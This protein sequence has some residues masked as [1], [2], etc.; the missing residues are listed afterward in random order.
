MSVQSIFLKKIAVA[1]ATAAAMTAMLSASPVAAAAP[2]T[3]PRCTAARTDECRE[4][5]PLRAYR[6][7]YRTHHAHHR[8]ETDR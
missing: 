8:A 2:S 1:G 5:G 7:H 4:E 6:P 3:Y